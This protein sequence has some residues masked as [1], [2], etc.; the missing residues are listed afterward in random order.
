M[1]SGRRPTI[2]VL[3]LL[4]ASCNA[5]FGETTTTSSPSGATSSTSVTT[6]GRPT[7]TTAAPSTTTI[8]SQPDELT[9]LLAAFSDMGPGWDDLVFP[10]GDAA[11]QLG[12]SAGGDGL[13]LGPEYGAQMGDG[14]WWFLDAAKLRLAHFGEDGGYLGALAIPANLLVNGQYFQ[15]QMPQAMDNGWLISHGFRGEGST[16]LLTL[17]DGSISGRNIDASVSWSNTDGGYLYGLDVED[18][19]PRRLDPASGIVEPT[20]W[21]IGRD[22]SRYMVRID[23][24]LL[25]VEMPDVGV[26]KTLMMR[27]SEDGET[28]VRGGIEVETGVDGTIFIVIYGAPASD[29]S[30]GVGG[31]VMIGPN[32]F[33]SDAETIPNPF[34]SADPGSPAHLGV[35][36]GTSTP[37]LM[38]IGTDGVH[39][40][41]HRG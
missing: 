27:D 1:A 36:P 14:S 15:Y 29:E 5:G 30:R 25:I 38:V 32:G 13:L 40:H 3:G 34:S 21:L 35:R 4:L 39:V 33:V 23:Q 22:G 2:L 28:P 6:T 19:L 31:L 16:A 20:D 8:P 9:L 11:A 12:T 26:T 41:I 24:D 10:Y 17:A 37:W 18:G 7:T